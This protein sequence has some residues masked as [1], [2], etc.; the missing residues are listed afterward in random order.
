[1][2]RSTLYDWKNGRH[3]PED[4]GGLLEVVRI[5]L[6]AAG[7]RGVP[8]APAPEDEPSW[9]EL[10]AEAKRAKAPRVA[11]SRTNAAREIASAGHGALISEWDPVA[12]GVH[13]A[14]GG[15][16]LPGYV[17]RAH[18]D[19]LRT[20]LDPDVT[21]SRIVVLRGG[22]STGKTRAAYEAIRE[23][24]PDWQV[25]QVQTRAILAARINDGITPGTVVW[26]D[27]LRH[28]ADHGTAIF[29]ELDDLLARTARV[30]VIA[31][32]W[33]THWG[34]YTRYE[35]PPPDRPDR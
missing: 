4:D 13:R 16:A 19:L 7:H 9:R 22:S 29:A 11:G 30:V 12:F 14:I 1:M 27:E 10:L 33:P 26:L 17:P 31:T 25:D 3:L 8:V 2:S 6:A 5:C 32:L 23:C 21:A 35:S 28:F 34:A 20:V 18:D 24:L 15:D